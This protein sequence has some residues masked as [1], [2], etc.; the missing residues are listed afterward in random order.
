MIQQLLMGGIHDR[1]LHLS[2]MHSESQSFITINFL[3]AARKIV[4]EAIGKIRQQ[5][6]KRTLFVP[7]MPGQSSH[8]LGAQQHLK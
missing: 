7:L 5:E 2:P 3:V 1:D 8:N 4:R 6:E